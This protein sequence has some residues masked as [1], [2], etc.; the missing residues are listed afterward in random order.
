MSGGRDLQPGQQWA[1][2]GVRL[3]RPHGDQPL[4]EQPRRQGRFPRRQGD[5]LFDWEPGTG[6]DTYLGAGRLNVVLVV[7]NSGGAA[8]ND[9]L[10]SDGQGDVI[11]TRQNLVPFY[12]FTQGIQQWYLEPSTGPATT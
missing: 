4:H 7:G 6:T 3:A 1:V 2:D 8:E 10:T 5:N 11:F 12:L 9:S